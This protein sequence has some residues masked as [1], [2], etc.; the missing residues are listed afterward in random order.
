VSRT[1]T[2]AWG[3]V[4]CNN[5]KPQANFVACVYQTLGDMLRSNEL[6]DCDF[7]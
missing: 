6:K 3:K 1:F 2:V 4:S 5:G 7:D